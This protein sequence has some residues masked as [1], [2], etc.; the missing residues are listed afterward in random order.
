MDRDRS[1]A[2]AAAI[3][4]AIA[5]FCTVPLARTVQRWVDATVGRQA[6]TYVVLAA[7]VVAVVFAVRSIRRAGISWRGYG[8]VAAS[9]VTFAVYTFGLD[10]SPEESFHF[11]EY[12]VLA[13]L[14]FGALSKGGADLTIYGTTF[15]LGASVGVVDEGIQ[16]LIP[17][18]VWDL[19][20]IGLNALGVAL[21]VV[22]IA[23]GIQPAHVE[24]RVTRRGMRQLLRAYFLFLL[25]LGPCLL[26]T[27][28]RITWYASRVPGLGHLL[29]NESLM[30]QYGYLYDDPDIGRFR[31]RFAPDAL[32]ETDRQRAPDAAKILDRYARGEQYGPFLKIYTAQK[33][34]FVHE[35]RVHLFRRNHYIR[36][37][38]GLQPGH[39]KRKAHYG[40]VVRENQIL[41]KYF[42]RTLA[43]S[44]TA[45]LPP[46]Q[47]KQIRA[48][49]ELDPDYES[50]V[51]MA[52]FTRIGE[53]SVVFGLVVAVLLGFVA[54]RRMLAMLAILVTS[55]AAPPVSKD[56]GDP[57]LDLVFFTDVHARTEWQTPDALALAAK[58]IN[59][60]R[61][62]LVI[63]GGDVITDGFQSTA[64][65]VAPRWTA[66]LKMAKAIE[67]PLRHVIGNHD[68]VAADPDDGSP[69]AADPRAIWREKTGEPNSYFSFDH[70]GYHFVFLDSIEVGG[71]LRYRGHVSEAQLAWLD[72]DLAKVEP[73]TPIVAATHIPLLTSF[74]AATRG[75]TVAA[76]LNRVVTNNREVL[77][78]F[79][80]HDLVLVLQGH[81][82]ASEV[83]V[84]RGVTFLTG[85][86]LSAKWWRGPWL[87]TQEGFTVV[88]L[89]GRHVESRY[90]DLGWDA[91]RPA[92]D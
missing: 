83:I 88:R 73:G 7:G 48:E 36:A 60:E 44:T 43:T 10:A 11:V 42:P 89:R 80:G 55:C 27:P 63:A 38:K 13:L 20:D 51:S 69:P 84:W 86:A 37:S 64:E 1:F 33:D 90:V 61:P 8:W 39:P 15:L 5:I 32:A 59:A 41:E 6:F 17:E 66:Y 14:L 49:A 50:P 53:R 72:E 70:A 31:S 87:G 74:Y 29:E 76:P 35:A 79:E 30:I 18:R 56:H 68:L 4:W 19:R 57:A 47:L 26:N 62:Q 34:P 91:R 24:R 65:V 58:Q 25:L 46:E 67:A 81:L 2:W 45:T 40:I 52:L 9:A 23:F 92:S 77:D 75:S 16:W 22:P 82:H 21:V 28:A 3:A 71:P 78:K 85:G 54:R 12:G